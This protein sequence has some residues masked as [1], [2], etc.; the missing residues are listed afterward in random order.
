M[1]TQTMQTMTANPYTDKGTT[2]PIMPIPPIAANCF[3]IDGGPV[4][5]VLESRALTGAVISEHTAQSGAAQ[6]Q[7]AL[8]D[9]GGASLHVFGAE[10]GLEYL[11]FDCFE[12]QPH[13][14]YVRQAEQL[15]QVLSIDDVAVDP[16]EWTMICIRGRLA[17]MLG[18]AGAGELSDAVRARSD[19]VKAGVEKVAATIRRLQGQMTPN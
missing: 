19:E 12:K 14:H 10:D 17:E 7:E 2:Y 8:E 13:Y 9:D 5:F 3:P 11:R 1:Q 6:G 18:Y 4:K 16:I 15:N